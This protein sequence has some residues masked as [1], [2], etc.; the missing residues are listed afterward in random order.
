[1]H[2]DLAAYNCPEY[3]NITDLG[4]KLLKRLEAITNRKPT[5]KGI[6][7]TSRAGSE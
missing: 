2:F 4:K 7:H 3:K 1:M 6:D 5:P